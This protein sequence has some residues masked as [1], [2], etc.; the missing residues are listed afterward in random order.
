[1]REVLIVT[2]ILFGLFCVLPITLLFITNSIGIA[3]I[4]FLAGMLVLQYMT[5]AEWWT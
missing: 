4:A 3:V 5:Q 1:M 2:S